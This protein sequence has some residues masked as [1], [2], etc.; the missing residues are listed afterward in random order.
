M[1]EPGLIAIRHHIH[2]VYMLVYNYM[3]C[4]LIVIIGKTTLALNLAI[5]RAR[6]GRDVWL[7]DGER[8]V[9]N[10]LS[11]LARSLG[12][13]VGILDAIAKQ[14]VTGVSRPTLYHFI[15]TRGLNSGTW[16]AFPRESGSYPIC[17]RPTPSRRHRPSQ[18]TCGHKPLIMIAS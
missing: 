18:A 9:V 14:R 12:Q 10:E 6:A 13:I 7:V 1:A 8:L 15:G 4:I 16:S 2:I 5:A 17:D 3:D 11:R